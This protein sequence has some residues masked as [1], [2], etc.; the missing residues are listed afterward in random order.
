MH[1][2]NMR[3]IVRGNGFGDVQ[4]EMEVCMRAMDGYESNGNA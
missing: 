4:E 2:G 3:R 1:G